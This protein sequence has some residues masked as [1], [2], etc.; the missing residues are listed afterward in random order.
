MPRSGSNPNWPG[1]S[2][3]IIKKD[4]EVKLKFDKLPISGAA[5]IA[6]LL[7]ALVLLAFAVVMGRAPAKELPQ[8]GQVVEMSFT[9]PPALPNPQKRVAEQPKQDTVTPPKEI[10]HAEPKPPV[11]TT[12]E[13]QPQ[14]AD[15]TPTPVAET[16]KPAVDPP[17]S[18]SAKGN[19][20]PA[21]FADKART[22]VQSA[23]QYPYAAKM[24]HITGNTRVGFLYMDGLI[25][26]PRIIKSSGYDVLDRAALKAVSEAKYPPTPAE[27]EHKSLSLEI[28]VRFIQS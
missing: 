23:V 14:V 18:Q 20:V 21:T 17:T 7:E 19:D 5:L 10:H 12:P 4:S 27:L 8:Q 16:K 9:A 1:R 11:D 3:A 28:V 26:N 2:K 15:A 24:A 6:F 13:P 22:A 25:S